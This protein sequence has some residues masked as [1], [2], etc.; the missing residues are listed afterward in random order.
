MSFELTPD[1]R[2]F[3][4]LQT[5]FYDKMGSQVRLLQTQISSLTES[6][7][8]VRENI[9]TIYADAMS[10][11]Q[12]SASNYSYTPPSQTFYTPSS[13]LAQPMS[14]TPAAVE[15]PHQEDLMTLETTSH[16]FSDIRRP[17]NTE[18][19]ISLE[20]FEPDSEVV[21]I[22]R[23]GH[24]FNRYQLQHWFETNNT[25][26]PT[27]RTELRPDTTQLRNSTPDQIITALF[28]DLLLPSSTTVD[29]S[30]NVIIR[31]RRN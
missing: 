27:C 19:P 1:Q 21:Q 29:A 13:R 15:E 23:C 10:T 2:L 17:L 20:P 11:R 9:Q 22:N 8:H 14:F 26:C 3:L 28:Y 24:I 6:M 18:C 5:S 31:P 12:R 25:R 16:Y 4:N 30:N 7:F